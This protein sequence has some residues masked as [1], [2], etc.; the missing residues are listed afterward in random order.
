MTQ[1]TTKA[2]RIDELTYFIS[3]STFEVGVETQSMFTQEL[4]YRA[5]P[6]NTDNVDLNELF[7]GKTKN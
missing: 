7:Y 4:I 5:L 2:Y 1:K 6:L 3:G